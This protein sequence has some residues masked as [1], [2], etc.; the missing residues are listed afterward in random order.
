MSGVN[1]LL[2]DALTNIGR[3]LNSGRNTPSIWGY[4]AVQH[5][6]ADYPAFF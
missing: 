4:Q 6:D 5:R 3:V 2:N 1:F